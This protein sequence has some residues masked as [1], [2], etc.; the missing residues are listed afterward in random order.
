MNEHEN[1]AL[2]AA[3]QAV[4]ST[5][6]EPALP[7][8]TDA[9]VVGGSRIRRRRAALA[10]AGALIIA[11][12][13]AAVAVNPPWPG[14]ERAP[15]PLTPASTTHPTPHTPEPARTAAEPLPSGH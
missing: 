9:A 5:E 4:L 1:D 3:F 15:V 13:I 12:S 8:V 14:S 11:A 10:T 6:P 7:S 2:H